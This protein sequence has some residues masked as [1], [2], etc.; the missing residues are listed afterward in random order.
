MAIM[1]PIK[2]DY[3]FVSNAI[4]TF[5]CSHVT[6]FNE[7]KQTKRGY[8]NLSYSESVNTLLQSVINTFLQPVIQ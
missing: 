7:K 1:H 2:V 5:Y 4:V 3:G 8:F 6:V